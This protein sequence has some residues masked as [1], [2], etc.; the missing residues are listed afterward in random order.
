[1]R[2]AAKLRLLVRERALR[3]QKRV[4]PLVLFL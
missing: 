2:H 1:M 3:Q 4:V